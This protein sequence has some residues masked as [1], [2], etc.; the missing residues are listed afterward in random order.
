LVKYSQFK[1][2]GLVLRQFLII[3]LLDGGGPTDSALCLHLSEI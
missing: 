1:I 2:L 3:Y